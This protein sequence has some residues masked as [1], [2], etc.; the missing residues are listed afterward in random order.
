MQK[1]IDYD[2]LSLADW[3]KLM[4][5]SSII[6]KE[7]DLN[8]SWNCKTCK[9][10]NLLNRHYLVHGKFLHK[11]PDNFWVYKE[12]TFISGNDLNSFIEGFLCCI[13]PDCKYHQ[14]NI[15]KEFW[16]LQ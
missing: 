7:K 10:G 2:S 13:N 1:N 3:K 15:D 11:A 14:N 6:E 16:G 4:K 5:D 12:Q 9:D 8:N